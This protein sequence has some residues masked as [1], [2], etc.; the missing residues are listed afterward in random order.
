[1]AVL[2]HSLTVYH[3]KMESLP[4]A[5]QPVRCGLY[6]N[7]STGGQYTQAELVPSLYTSE[8][9]KQQFAESSGRSPCNH[10]TL[11]SED[12]DETKKKG[13]L[14]AELMRLTGT[15]S[16]VAVLEV[17]NSAC[18]CIHIYD[19]VCA[20]DTGASKKNVQQGLKGLKAKEK[21]D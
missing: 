5:W 16:G 6:A 4:K 17:R 9:P 10:F 3:D 14:F 20:S 11:Y 8:L 13:K 15:D 7:D 2:L 12:R 18:L 19:C 1:M 21:D